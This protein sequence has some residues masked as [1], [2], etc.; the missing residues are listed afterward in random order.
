MSAKDGALA[1]VLESLVVG[2][3]KSVVSVGNMISRTT[4][5]CTTSGTMEALGEVA[6]EGSAGGITLILAAQIPKKGDTMIF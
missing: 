4:T 1:S 6:T 2:V 5:F 3:G